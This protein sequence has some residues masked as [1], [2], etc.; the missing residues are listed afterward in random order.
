MTLT[1][2]EPIV[3]PEDGD[4]PPIVSQ[5]EFNALDDRVKALE[6]GG[7][8]VSYKEITATYDGSYGWIIEPEDVKAGMYLIVGDTYSYA[9]MYDGIS[10]TPMY[11]GGYPIMNGNI[12]E[13]Y[14][15][16]I[17]VYGE[18]V[19]AYAGKMAITVKR[20]HYS[21]AVWSI[22]SGTPSS[23]LRVYYLGSED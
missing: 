20:L 7:V 6:E 4:M 17:T 12:Y 22:I 8:G 1:P 10:A 14:F 16:C 18:G 3:V 21:N 11:G 5:R 13:F 19:P 23:G 9:M 15:P 2:I